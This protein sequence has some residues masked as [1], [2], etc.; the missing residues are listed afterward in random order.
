[1]TVRCSALSRWRVKEDL[2]G[3]DR[4]ERRAARWEQFHRSRRALEQSE[5][6]CPE[7]RALSRDWQR[8]APSDRFPSP[9]PCWRHRDERKAL[10]RG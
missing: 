10:G 1:M 3:N 8:R 4:L 7:C 2:V 9:M 5:A 6:E